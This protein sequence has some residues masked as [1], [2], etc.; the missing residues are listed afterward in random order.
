MSECNE[1]K[2]FNSYDDG[3]GRWD[4]WCGK[5]DK[6]DCWDH[7]IAETCEFYEEIE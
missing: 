1:C 6:I 2:H 5:T 3:D 4:I 7:S